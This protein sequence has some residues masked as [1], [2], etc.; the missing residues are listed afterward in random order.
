[1][2]LNL[3]TSLVGYAELKR[4]LRALEQREEMF[5]TLSGRKDQSIPP[6]QDAILAD[7]GQANKIDLNDRRVCQQLKK[8]LEEWADKLPRLHLSFAV[9]PSAQVTEQLVTWLRANIDRNVLIAIGLQPSIA[10]GCVI[11]TNNKVFDMSLRSFID[12]QN[13]YL[14]K[15]IRGAASGN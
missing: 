9:E 6:I 1:M 5:I 10:A 4:V 15:L 11:R 14:V 3:P 8:Y 13:D 12:R 2:E 7:V